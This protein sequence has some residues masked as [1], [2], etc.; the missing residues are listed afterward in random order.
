MAVWS[1]GFYAPTTG[2]WHD[3]LAATAD[4]KMSFCQVVN[5][6]A[7]ETARVIVAI[8]ASDDTAILPP[9]GLTIQETGSI[10][11]TTYEYVITAVKADGRE[12]EA[13]SKISTV[14]GP[15]SLST[16]NYHTLTWNAVSGA[17]KYR[18][19]CRI[20]GE[21]STVIKVVETTDL[22]YS[23][24]GAMSDAEKWPWV[25]MTG[26]TALLAYCD[27]PPGTGLEPISRPI[28]IA[29]GD[30]IMLYSTGAISAFASGEV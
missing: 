17:A 26:V 1:K 10:G 20:G 30:K 9:T 15:S 3:I 18:L 22:T 8:G 23:N 25:N 2:A 7:S 24:K 16:D 28:P 19:Y 27:L 11:T 13:S 29:N 21:N 5:I 12:T 4:S 6:S 14:T